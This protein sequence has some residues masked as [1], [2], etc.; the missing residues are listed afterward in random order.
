M[1]VQ[2]FQNV[3]AIISVIRFFGASPGRFYNVH[4]LNIMKHPDFRFIGQ[5]EKSFF[6]TLFGGNEIELN[7][8]DSSSLSRIHHGSI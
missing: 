8:Q 6:E 1:N 2:F 3:G 7:P 4:I 5:R